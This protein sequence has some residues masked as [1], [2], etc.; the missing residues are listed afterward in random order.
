MK[1]KRNYLKLILTLV[2]FIV[3]LLL[4]FII[5]SLI[6]IKKIEC[7][8]QYGPCPEEV[9]SKIKN[10]KSKSLSQTKKEI[11]KTLGTEFLVQNYSMQ[12]K[13]PNTLKVN[14]VL[15]KAQFA[16]NNFLVDRQGYIVSISDNPNLPIINWSDRGGKIGQKV[17]DD[18]LFTL[19]LLNGL[20]VLYN[21]KNGEVKDD[22][23]VIALPSG[24]N[25]IFPLGSDK[26][27]D[28]EYYL[29]AVR[30]I[31]TKLEV[32]YPNKYKELDLRFTNPV[33]R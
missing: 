6:N 5:P 32:E 2:I 28:I 27:R 12:Y 19:N 22:G 15:R 26:S 18:E 33:L 31:I 30:M 10:Q 4:P 14:L 8:T 21:V 17:Q 9:K 11:N 23:L 1:K 24:L 29:G 16:L 3:I 20:Y 25:V 13:F 7:E